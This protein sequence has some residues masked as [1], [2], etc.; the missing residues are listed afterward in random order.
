M[1]DFQLAH[2]RLLPIDR[3]RIEAIKGS[4]PDVATDVAAIR[5][6]LRVAAETLPKRKR[7]KSPGGA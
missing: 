2:I 5:K 3:E 6:A 1:P 4:D 7:K